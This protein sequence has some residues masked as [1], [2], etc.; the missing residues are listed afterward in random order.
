MAAAMLKH[1]ATWQQAVSVAALAAS[2]PA[3]Q[4]PP[5]TTAAKGTPRIVADTTRVTKTPAEKRK[6]KAARKR[7]RAAAAATAEATDEE[8][9]PKTLRLK[10]PG[11]G[12]STGL[13]SDKPQFAPEAWSQV[14]EKF[15]ETFPEHCSFH[16][17]TKCNRKPGECK[18]SHD[19]P[20]GFDAF[21]KECEEL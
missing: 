21:K 15:K 4:P 11:T 7:E 3:P 2:F 8:S 1:D 12:K 17:L 16:C 18:F 13:W 19:T 5:R 10:G 6:E 14:R 9:E 20:D